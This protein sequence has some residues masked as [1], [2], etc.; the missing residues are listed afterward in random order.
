MKRILYLFIALL[1]FVLSCGPSVDT[2]K[3]NWEANQRHAEDLMRNYPAYKKMIKAKLNEAT[4]A[5]DDA[6][7]I[8]D[9][10]QRAQKMSDANDLIEKGPV[11]NLSSLKSKID[12]VDRKYDR[13]NSIRT[14]RDY[15]NRAD[16]ALDEGRSAIRKAKDALNEGSFSSISDAEESVNK[17]YS[18]LETAYRNMDNL[19]SAIDRVNNPTKNTDNKSTDSKKVS[20]DNT[21]KETKKEIAKTIKC[22]YC[23]TVND[24]SNA[25]CKSC[26]APLA[27][28]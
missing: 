20:N 22:E 26:G 6:L 7:K 10:K 8:S 27:K 18:R 14:P 21:V 12:D 24:A 19:I 13:L 4:S 23:G 28:K 1:F 3:K 17:A 5:W 16:D 25:K 11:G 15:R 2:E 9:E